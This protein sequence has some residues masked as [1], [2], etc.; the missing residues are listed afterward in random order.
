MHKNKIKAIGLLS[1]G[2]D[3]LLAAKYLQKLGIEVIGVKFI[4]G[5]CAS[6][7]E[8]RIRDQRPLKEILRD[9]EKSLGRELG[10]EVKF[11][12]ISRTFFKQVVLHPKHGYGAGVNP[13][14]DCKIYMFRKARLMM[15]K[16]GAQMVFTGEVL[17]QRPMSQHRR[18]LDI[19]AK[20]SGLENFLLRPLSANKLPVTIPE[21]EGLIDRS[22]LLS[23]EGR[24]RSQQMKLA[25]ELG[26]HQYAQPAGGCYLADKS[27]TLKIR[28]LMKN[29]KSISETDLK[30]LTSGRQFRLSPGVK[31]IVGRDQF[32]N[33][34]LE[35]HKRGHGLLA[36]FNTKGPSA[37]VIGNPDKDEKLLAARI[38]AR[39][40]DPVQNGP[41]E[42]LFTK[43]RDKEILKAEPFK[44]EEVVSYRIG[45]V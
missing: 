13:C 29:K 4:T 41:V 28:D 34:F 23:I 21:K 12:D 27:F 39:Y 33:H 25:E 16:L 6:D 15:K 36:S 20:E 44:P 45:L 9:E 43:G 19:I 18:A 35:R 24:S 37:L 22:K 38:L 17:H 30:F 2:L 42:V 8:R 32:E 40:S 26:I 14:I 10:F 11:V 3:S 7:R 5:F 1:G 31:L